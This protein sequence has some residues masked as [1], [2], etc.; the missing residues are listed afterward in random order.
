MSINFVLDAEFDAIVGRGYYFS[1]DSVKAVAASGEAF[2]PG[3]I[4][5]AQLAT[6]RRDNE[7]K[8][9]FIRQAVSGRVFSSVLCGGQWEGVPVS[10]RCL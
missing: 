7:G 6:V 4:V 5:Q 1:L 3:V 10:P 9:V 8:T 2:G